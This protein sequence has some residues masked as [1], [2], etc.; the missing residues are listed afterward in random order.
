MSNSIINKLRYD[1]SSKTFDEKDA[2]RNPLTQ[3]DVWMNEALQSE[4]MEP[5]ALVLSTVDSMS[6]PSS[7]IVL[8]RGYDE[9]GFVFFTN[10]NSRK[11][12]N[13][14]VNQHVCLNFF[15]QSLER[16]IR[17]EGV[18]QKIATAASDEYFHSRPL[19]SRLGAWASNQSEK[20]ASREVLE[21]K[22][23]ELEEKFAD[24]NVPRPPHWG[25]YV[26]KPNYYEFWQGRNSRLHDRIAYELTNNH[27]QIARLSP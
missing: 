19:G 11:G 7:R 16:Q 12:D 25:G 18:V 24:G 21:S 20:I 17:I 9:N 1:Y 5:N 22:Q 27:W 3:F 10:Y 8:L 6:K 2:L 26:C 15:H 23:K 13:M 4:V 14:D